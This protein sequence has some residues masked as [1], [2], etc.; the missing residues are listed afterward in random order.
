MPVEI[1]ASASAPRYG[2]SSWG[3]VATEAKQSLDNVGQFL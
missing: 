2:M 3:V 1:A